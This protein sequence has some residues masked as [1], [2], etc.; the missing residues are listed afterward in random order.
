MTVTRYWWHLLVVI[1]ISTYTKII[2]LLKREKGWNF[3]KISYFF[4]FIY[5]KNPLRCVCVV[6][7]N[8]WMV[9]N[10]IFPVI[11]YN[12]FLFIFFSTPC[13]IRDLYLLIGRVFN[14]P[15]NFYLLIRWSAIT[16]FLVFALGCIRLHSVIKGG[17]RVF[18]LEFFLNFFSSLWI[19]VRIRLKTWDLK[20]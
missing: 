13:T 17:P 12:W 1:S 8:L 11:S 18:H 7:E 16:K 10:G 5:L 14:R 2:L 19:G 3:S 9:K 6:L 20:S 4:I 15:I